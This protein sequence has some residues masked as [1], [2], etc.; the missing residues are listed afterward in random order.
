VSTE[1]HDLGIHMIAELFRHSGW[2]TAYLGADIPHHD[3]VTFVATRKPDVLAVSATM[4]GHV[5]AISD[6]VAAVRSERRCAGVSVLVGGRPFTRN[7]SLAGFVGAD[8]WATGPADAL[9]LCQSW[10]GRDDS[11]GA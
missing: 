2:D 10:T 11:S 7:P 6:L 9:E 8:G 4:V 5:H 3:V 1:T